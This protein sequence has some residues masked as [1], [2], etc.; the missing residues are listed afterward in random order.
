[1]KTIKNNKLY[2]ALLVSFL[3]MCIHTKILAQT[4]VCGD[5][6]LDTATEECDLGNPGVAT[7]ALNSDDPDNN[8]GCKTDCTKHEGWT[9]TQTRTEYKQKEIEANALFTGD[10]CSFQAQFNALN[11]SNFNAGA[12]EQSCYEYAD[13]LRKFKELNGIIKMDCTGCTDTNFTAANGFKQRPDSA[14]A[15]TPADY[16]VNCL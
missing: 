9:C 13:K 3:V 6:S 14:S 7:T 5:G 16:P 12:N 8:F 2:S 11:C 4:S 15:P 10:L 1:M